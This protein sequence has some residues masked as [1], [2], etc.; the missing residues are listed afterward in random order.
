MERLPCAN[1]SSSRKHAF[2]RFHFPGAGSALGCSGTGAEAARLLHNPRG[3]CLEPPAMARARPGAPHTGQVRRAPCPFPQFR[4]VI[5]LEFSGSFGPMQRG[6]EPRCR[7]APNGSCI[8]QTLGCGK[9]QYD[10]G[11]DQGSNFDPSCQV[12]FKWDDDPPVT[13]LRTSGQ[14]KNISSDRI[15]ALRRNSYGGDREELNGVVPRADGS[16]FLQLTSCPHTLA[17]RPASLNTTDKQYRPGAE[18]R[19]STQRG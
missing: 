10:P 9:T 4:Y 15:I 17:S 7:G 19:F 12:G 8:T 18:R 2:P 6:A 5:R 3:P 11:Q 14:L 1:P 16:P 13:W